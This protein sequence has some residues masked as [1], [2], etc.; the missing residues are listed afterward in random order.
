ME[1]REDDLNKKERQK[2]VFMR[3]M[4]GEKIGAFY[5]HAPVLQ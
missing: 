2:R 4:L 1:A 5:S 3:E